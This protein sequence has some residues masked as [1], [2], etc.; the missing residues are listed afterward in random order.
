MFGH[1]GILVVAG[2]SDVRVEMLES[3]DSSVAISLYGYRSGMK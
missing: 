2:H 3:G 1:Y